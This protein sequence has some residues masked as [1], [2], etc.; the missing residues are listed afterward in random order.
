MKVMK[1]PDYYGSVDKVKRMAQKDYEDLGLENEDQ[2]DDLVEDIL[3]KLKSHIDSRLAQGEIDEEDKRYKAVC[4]IAERKVL[5]MFS[6][7]QQLQTGDI[8]DIDEL[9]THIINTTDAIRD[10]NE[11]LMNFHVR[12]V[13]VSWT[14]KEE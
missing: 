5:D 14:G 13:R 10:L 9:S 12:K 7:I 3:E 4:D 6:V 2:Y 1:V 11:E 8:V